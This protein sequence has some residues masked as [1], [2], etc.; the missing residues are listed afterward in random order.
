MPFSS[1]NDPSDL[2]RA[3]RIL[4]SAWAKIQEL[5]L[6]HGGREAQRTSLAYVVAGLLKSAAAEADLVDLAIVQFLGSREQG[7]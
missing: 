7:L 5:D 2:A 6:V 4:D 1:L 3:C